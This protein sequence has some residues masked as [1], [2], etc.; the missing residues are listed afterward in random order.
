MAGIEDRV[1]H[2]REVIEYHT[3]KYYIDN[4]PEISDH[5]F[6]M[7]MK[8]L[9]RLEAEHPELASPN[10]PTKRVGGAPLEG[11]VT[12]EHTVPML[13]MDNTYNDEELRAFD[14]RVTRG[15]DGQKPRYVV[16]PKIDGV[17]VSLRYEVGAFTL[18][19]TRGDGRNGD[20]ITAN[21]RTIRQIPLVI[22][23]PAEGSP[24]V[25]DVLEARGEVYMPTPE[26][27][28]LNAERESA[29][30][31]L[32][33]NPR[34]ATAGTLKLLDPRLAAERR[35]EIFVYG[36]G[37]VEPEGYATHWEELEALRAFGFRVN[38][39]SQLC[40]GI[41]EVL[42]FCR[43]FG[44]VRRELPYGVDGVVVKVDSVDHQRR[45]GATAKAPRW[46]IAFKYPA[47]QALTRIE[48]IVVQVGKTGILT[49]VANLKPVQL[50]GTTVKRAT[51]HNADE[52]ERKDIMVGDWVLVEKAGEIIPQVVEVVKDKRD[53]SQKPFRMPRK[54]PV[55]GAP[56]VQDEGEVYVRCSSMRCPAQLKA[57]LR[58][59]AHRNAMDIETLGA[60]LIDQLVDIGLV[61]DVADL[62]SLDME[63]VAALERMGRKSAENLL[64]AV[65]ESK[66]RD[67]G[68][69]IAA[70][71][72]R[73]V[74]A[75]AA[76]TLARHFGSLKALETASVDELEA[77]PEIGP[78]MAECIHDFF[79]SAENLKVIRKLEEAGVN[80][81]L[82]QPVEEGARALEGKRF[83]VT[84]S[85][86]HYS[87]A[88]IEKLIQE[89]GGKVSSS[90][91]SKTDYVVA[92]SSPG[93]KLEKARR[94]GINVISEGDFMK[95]AGKAR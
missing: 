13:S 26:F 46:M 8:E 7:L 73:H 77:I 49:P 21:L 64:A 86:E 38:E 72:I 59:F 55:C 83:V 44:K 87:R 47:E 28:R 81:R 71:N 88:E 57:R 50:A 78:V 4:A 1:R 16:E 82:L 48:S 25:P 68:N 39:H 74:G 19:A 11:F 45:L 5:D 37:A 60:A 30:E 62:Y 2:L 22:R 70:L 35:L 41:D 12:V 65:E 31:A 24:S 27:E 56:V 14:A 51:L 93:S 58:F 34:N 75:A 42:E 90:V 67:L 80:T 18:G 91:S 6:D 43:R 84:G 15:L 69:L 3:R 17:A 36:V 33:A 79:R 9:E 92:G 53:G 32:F 66:T 76:R 85:L 61:A 29:D 20:D 94:L 63:S 95:L 40:A 23:P 54:C 89:L 10:S 52:I